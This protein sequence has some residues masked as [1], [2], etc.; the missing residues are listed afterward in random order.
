ML[1]EATVCSLAM[2]LI[3]AFENTVNTMMTGV[4]GPAPQGLHMGGAQRNFIRSFECYP[5]AYWGSASSGQSEALERGDKIVLPASCL[6]ELSRMNIQFPM[7]FQVTNPKVSRISHCSVLEFTA[8][9]GNVYMPMWMM[10]NLCLEPGNLVTLRNV[11]M[12]KGTYVKLRPHA[13]K[14]I[15]L[16]NP[17][18]VLE[19]ALRTF[20]CLTQNDTI[21]ISPPGLGKF[22]LDV[23]EV[24]PG[25]RISIIETDVVLDFEEPKD[26]EAHT[27]KQ[28]LRAPPKKK[29]KEE[30]KEDHSSSSKGGSWGQ[31][32]DDSHVSADVSSSVQKKHTTMSAPGGKG[33]YFS[34]LGGGQ[35][36][37]G[38]AIK[39]KGR[40][41]ALG[42]KSSGKSKA[43]RISEVVGNMEYIYSVDPETQERTL[44]R[45]LPIRKQ[46][47]GGNGHRLKG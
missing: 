30:E 31:Y 8:P 41:S 1:Y 15:E 6:D 39:T 7:M 38:K 22:K 36:L 47:G 32:D 5:P 4:L 27:A 2:N 12:P 46:L 29:K 37:N 14:F 17:K 40:G 16:P 42:S 18:V 10:E 26:Y 45:R 33:D 35:R 43:K 11:E 13:T 23:V 24:R 28:G 3:R 44:L 19:K 9:E 25:N 21:T 34:K 20:S